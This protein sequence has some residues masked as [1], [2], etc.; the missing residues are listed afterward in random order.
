M[1]KDNMAYWNAFLKQFKESRRMANQEDKGNLREHI[2][3]TK[4]GEKSR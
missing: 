2:F 3:D 4:K 1:E